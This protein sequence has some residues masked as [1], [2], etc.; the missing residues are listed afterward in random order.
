ML[1]NTF[2]DTFFIQDA[3]FLIRLLPNFYLEYDV[4]V[5]FKEDFNNL[6]IFLF[7]FVCVFFKNLILLWIS[8]SVLPNNLLYL[9]EYY[10]QYHLIWYIIVAYF[11][12]YNN[13]TY[14]F[15]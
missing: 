12:S 10:S 7:F 2:P 14:V 15:I 8:F 13:N 11:C 4:F 9:P 6:I 5:L 3:M 1:Y